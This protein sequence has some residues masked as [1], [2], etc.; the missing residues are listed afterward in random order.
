M[1]QEKIKTFFK[2]NK[3]NEEKEKFFSNISK[4]KDR[5]KLGK[6]LLKLKKMFPKD[7]ILMKMIIDE[8][9]ES[10][11]AKH[12]L[13]YDCFDSDEE[14]KQKNKLKSSLSN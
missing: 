8:F 1:E 13:E 3:S 12:P 10:K 11:I 9:K 14:G 4:P 2:T 7:P 6:A 5:L